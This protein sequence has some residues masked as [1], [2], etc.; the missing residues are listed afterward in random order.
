LL[1]SR[2]EVLVER[3]IDVA[4]DEC[5][6][7]A[8]TL[9]LVAEAW[10]PTVADAQEDVSSPPATEKAAAPSKDTG[11]APEPA[12]APAGVPGAPAASAAPPA[13][14]AAPTAVSPRVRH[15]RLE[16]AVGAAIP[17]ESGSD[18]TGLLRVS[19][20]G[21]LGRWLAGLRGHFET[22]GDLH[23][24]SPVPSEA[25]AI[26]TSRTAAD[27]F[28]GCKLHDGARTEVAVLVSAGFEF[29]SAHVSGYTDLVD[30]TF[31]DPEVGAG[32]R[33]TWL[34]VGDVAFS[35]GLDVTYAWRRET[36]V[37]GGAS[38]AAMPHFRTRLVAGVS[39]SPF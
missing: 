30:E 2:G 19:A 7:L 33:A 16:A 1:L 22:A 10:L 25:G 12:P 29:V 9:A 21:A 28:L 3:I 34:A 20:E 17:L 6:G 26:S 18:V 24:S 37:T 5:P 35:G 8:H 23:V 15:F 13:P 36:F 38:I 4:A 31:V 14:A 39:W 27:G 32:A 11:A